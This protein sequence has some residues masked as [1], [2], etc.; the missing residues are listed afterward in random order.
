MHQ[1]RTA[2]FQIQKPLLFALGIG[3]LIAALAPFDLAFDV[4]TN[5]SAFARASA[6][7]VIGLVG[8]VAARRV[9]LNFGVKDLA[10]PIGLPLLIAAVVAA[11]VA[12]VDGF[13]F[14]G[15]LSTDYVQIFSTVG[16]VGRLLYFMPRAYNE[17]LI[18]R[19]C[20]M[21]TLIWII[22]S[23][24]HDAHHRP[25]DGAYWLGI[26]LAQV[27]NISINVVAS[28]HEPVTPGLLFYDGVRYIV[29]GVIWGYLYW[30]HGFVAAEIASVGTHP[31]LQPALGFLLGR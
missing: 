13:L 27:I 24:W 21:S 28:S 18:Y 9:G 29:P 11:G 6:M 2:P 16:L 17:N 3:S 7:P 19:W 22:G 30:R 26:V 4:L 10:R 20:V 14:R 8:C 23:L 1:R 15:F 31:L 5:G 12:I 25:A